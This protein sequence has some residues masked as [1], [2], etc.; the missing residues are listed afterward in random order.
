VVS[1]E[2]L[3]GDWLL[4]LLEDNFEV[5]Q[6]TLGEPREFRLE[7]GV[8]LRVTNEPDLAVTAEPAG[9][10][11]DFDELVADAR[12]RTDANDLGAGVWWKAT[13]TG[14]F[15]IDFMDDQMMRVMSEE[16]LFRGAWRLGRGVALRFD[17]GEIEGPAPRGLRRGTLKIETVF[18]TPGPSH[19]LIAGRIARQQGALIRT[20]CVYATA[21]PL[22]AP[23]AVFPAKEDPSSEVASA[24]ELAVEGLPLH[25]AVMQFSKT[26][27]KEA[28]DRLLGALYSYEAAIAQKAGSVALILFVT[29]LEALTVPN[30][31]WKQARI[32]G[33]F[34]GFIKELCPSELDTIIAHGNFAEAFGSYTSKRRFL[35]ELYDMRSR[36]AHTGLTPHV[37]GRL[38][39]LQVEAQV[40]VALA[41]ELVRAA[42]HQ[43]LASPRSSLIGHPAL[44]SHQD[45]TLQQTDASAEHRQSKEN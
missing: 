27:N 36:L 7:G 15:G 41:S 20:L 21:V 45:E 13:L 10:E 14:E 42:I 8:L 11:V 28:V 33:R 44:S 19:G 22:A 5:Q 25:Q 24:P 34:I 31:P 1:R 17:P 12:S 35:S 9:R 38:H 43:F 4:R 3:F 18:W 26:E 2:E 37:F 30:A 16:Q 6:Q 40:R 29:A 23:A 32:T 39:D